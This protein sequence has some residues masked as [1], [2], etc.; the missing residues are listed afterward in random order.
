MDR[1][2]PNLFTNSTSI[3]VNTPC[4]GV[5]FMYTAFMCASPKE[6]LLFG[7]FFIA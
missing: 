1:P 5:L 4:C 2:K 3:D 6:Y 7:G